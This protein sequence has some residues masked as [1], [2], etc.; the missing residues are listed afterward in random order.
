MRRSVCSRRSPV[1]GR[2]CEQ[3]GPTAGAVGDN[4]QPHSVTESFSHSHSVSQ[5]PVLS[6]PSTIC[7]IQPELLK[8]P[9]EID[10]IAVPTH[11]RVA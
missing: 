11:Q 8:E 3:R 9:V 2:L 4:S 6:A 7:L 1:W 10:A 5:W